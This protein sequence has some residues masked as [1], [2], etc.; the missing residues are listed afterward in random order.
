MAIKK[1]FPQEIIR[2]KR[3]DCSLTDEEI[4]AFVC[5]I[6]ESKATEGQIAAFAMSVLFRG[7]NLRECAVLSVA[8][9]DS[10]EVLDW[11][12]ANLRGPLIDKH[13]SGGV[14]DCVSLMLAP[15]LAACGAH[16]PM[17]SGRGLGHSGGTLDKLC[18][19]PGY[20]IRP[21]TERFKK[22]VQSVGCAIV[23]QSPSLAPVD[24]RMYAVRDVTATVESV[25]LITA[26]ILSK[27]FAAGIDA[28]VMDVKTGNGAFT[29]TSKMARDLADNIVN[30]SKIV[31]IPVVSVITDMNQPLARSAGNSLEVLEAIAYLTGTS[32][33]QRLHEVVSTLGAELMVLG[34]LCSDG[35]MACGML[36]KTLADGS[37]AECFSSMVAA[38]G[39]PSDLI[40]RSDFHLS[41]A[42]VQ[43]PVIA[44]EK[45]QVLAIDTRS[46]GMTVLGLG[47]GRSG[48]DDRIDVSVGLSDLSRLGDEI[49]V[50]ME[51]AT[52]HARSE[53]DAQQAVSSVSSAV[54][55]GAGQALSFPLIQEIRRS[56]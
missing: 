11:K 50:G 2:R 27:K 18:S 13:S 24:G 28:L 43:V 6:N 1:F 49:D 26:S 47:G 17:I 19:I 53:S 56:P 22:I 38:L 46:L 29:A 21:D 54:T 5:A 45:G 33:D 7:M 9:R 42:P 16:V 12:S 36:E 10:G 40:E 8:M 4:K 25:P 20:C 37:A 52:V 14:G 3:D 30:V 32:R 15:M 35:S 34:G 44:K 55:I 41:A 48:F 23:G 39:G 51:I 31:G